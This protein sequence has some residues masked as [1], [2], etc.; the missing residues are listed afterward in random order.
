MLYAN[1]L[2]RTMCDL[3]PVYDVLLESGFA[4]LALM[5]DVKLVINTR[6]VS[7]SFSRLLSRV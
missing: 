2:L 3:L 6:I 7:Q 1:S 5:C 4:E